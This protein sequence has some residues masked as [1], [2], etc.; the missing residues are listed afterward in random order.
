MEQITDTNI[1]LGFIIQAVVNPPKP[2]REERCSKRTFKMIGSL[3]RFLPK[4][5][6][7]LNEYYEDEE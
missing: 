6:I 2:T 7:S 4:D 5:C 1:G 3:G